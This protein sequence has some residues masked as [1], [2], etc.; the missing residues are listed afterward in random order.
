[1]LGDL[2]GS[3]QSK[4]SAQFETKVA[5]RVPGTGN[6]VAVHQCSQTRD[7]HDRSRTLGTHHPTLVK[8]R[9]VLMQNTW[10]ER[11][12]PARGSQ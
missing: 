7:S 11:G 9:P 8:Q 4:D 2:Q 3:L 12:C 5:L 10:T 6:N 1:M